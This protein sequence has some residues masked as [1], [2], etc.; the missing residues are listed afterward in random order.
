MSAL[1][2]NHDRSYTARSCAI[3]CVRAWDVLMSHNVAV[4]SVEHV[5]ML[6]GA[7]GFHENDVI[8][9]KL[10]TGCLLCEQSVR[11]PKSQP[12]LDN[13]LRSCSRYCSLLSLY[14]FRPYPIRFESWVSCL[15]SSQIRRT[16]PVV[17]RSSPRPP[18]PSFRAPARDSA[19]SHPTFVAGNKRFAE[20]SW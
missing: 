3:S 6:A 20:L 14:P 10:Y 2:G 11:S 13:T 15:L 4:V 17:A 7:V 1:W 19:G 5:T 9:G 12:T 16:S 18:C 8:G